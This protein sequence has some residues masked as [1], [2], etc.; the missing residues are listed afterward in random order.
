[1]AK[2]R[3]NRGKQF[4]DQIRSALE[5]VP[6]TAVDR[7]ID[8]QAGYAG[9]GN[10]C[11]FQVYHYPHEFYLECKSC[12]GN[13]LSIHTNNPKNKYGA[14]S[15][16]QWEGMLK[17]SYVAGVVAGV[18]IWFIDH[19]IT[20]FVPIQTLERVRNEGAKSINIRN[21]KPLNYEYYIVPATKKRVF[22]EYDLL[23]FLG[24]D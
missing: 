2:N 3:I 6:E 20:I 9:V 8:P 14:V 24:G 5:A 15:N 7:L 21:L 16:T 4:E 23:N 13:T 10:I 19:D 11:D 22:F 1:M 12:Y 18:F 17:H